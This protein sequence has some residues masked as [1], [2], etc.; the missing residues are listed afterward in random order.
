MT[1]SSV[2]SF[3]ITLFISSAFVTSACTKNPRV[4]PFRI[5]KTA[6]AW[7]S[8]KAESQNNNVESSSAQP[9]AHQ[10]HCA[11]MYDTHLIDLHFFLS[12]PC[13]FSSRSSDWSVSDHDRYRTPN[14]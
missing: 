14:R 6:D 11:H 7:S 10:Q 2:G 9:H 4:T 12:N 8:G 3:S 1:M 13:F 5:Q